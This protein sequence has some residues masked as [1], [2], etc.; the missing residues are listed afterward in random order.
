MHRRQHQHIPNR[1]KKQIPRDTM[2]K[3]LD[4]LS[5]VRPKNMKSFFVVAPQKTKRVSFNTNIEA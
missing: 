2:K 1:K 4:P 3:N 5:I